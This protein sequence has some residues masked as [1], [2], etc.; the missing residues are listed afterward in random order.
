[1]GHGVAA[2]VGQR[3]SRRQLPPRP[4]PGGHAL[5]GRQ[6]SGTG[7]D[8]VPPGPGIAQARTDLRAHKPPQR[9]PA[10]MAR[11]PYGARPVRGA[12]VLRTT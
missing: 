3:R 4:G 6:G 12:P 11:T 9:I 5:D 8:P 7:H 10:W 2:S 1:L